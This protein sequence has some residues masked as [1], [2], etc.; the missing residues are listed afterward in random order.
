MLSAALDMVAS[1]NLSPAVVLLADIFPCFLV[2]VFT[3]I[4]I[5]LNLIS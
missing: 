1:A 3:L 5:I 2:Q 4:R